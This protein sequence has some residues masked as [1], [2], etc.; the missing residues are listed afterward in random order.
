[1]GIVYLNQPIKECWYGALHQNGN[2]VPLFP[3]RMPI[4]GSRHEVFDRVRLLA[5]MDPE[6]QAKWRG[7]HVVAVLQTGGFEIE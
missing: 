2:Y 5:A 7:W 6:F 1:M 4:C 3:K